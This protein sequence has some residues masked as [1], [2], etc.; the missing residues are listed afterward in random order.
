M[1]NTQNLAC[2]L[3]FIMAAAFPIHAF[4]D[5][6]LNDDINTPEVMTEGD[7]TYVTGGIGDEERN[8]L[9]ATRSNYNLHVL[10]STTSGAYT[11]NTSVT[12][13]DKAHNQLVTSEMGPIFYAKLPKGRYIVESTRRGE[14]KKQNIT[15]ASGKP[16]NVTFTWKPLK[17][18]QPSN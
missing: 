2:T 7:V 17:Q 6:G 1:K 4:A 14:T 9:E 3:A 5:A 10:N 18:P 11:G 13:F 16:V 15:I 12:I 8:V